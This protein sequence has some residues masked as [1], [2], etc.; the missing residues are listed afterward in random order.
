MA[1]T[2]G[3]ADVKKIADGPLFGRFANAPRDLPGKKAGD[4]A[5][6]KEADISD[7]MF[8]RN[9]KIVGGKTIDPLLKRNAEGRRRCASREDGNSLREVQGQTGQ[10]RHARGGFIR[11]AGR[12]SPRKRKPW[13]AGS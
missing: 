11:H 2:S 13:M 4:V 1:S 5:E 8:T 7:W 10:F 12:A 9:G 3:S 6:F